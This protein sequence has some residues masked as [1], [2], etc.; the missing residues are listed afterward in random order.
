MHEYDKKVLTELKTKVP[1][2]LIVGIWVI[3]GVLSVGVFV[4]SIVTGL[5]NLLS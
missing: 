1:V 2:R 4:L 3:A 5:R